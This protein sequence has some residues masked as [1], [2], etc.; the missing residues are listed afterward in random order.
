MSSK[1]HV[2]FPGEPHLERIIRRAAVAGPKGLEVRPI[3]GRC[4]TD[5]YVGGDDYALLQH[6]GYLS[7]LKPYR[8]APGVADRLYAHLTPRGKHLFDWAAGNR[9]FSPT[10]RG[11]SHAMPLKETHRRKAS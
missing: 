2:L 10:T 6:F 9:K 3:A 7:D 1:T 4:L 5:A 8:S 11:S